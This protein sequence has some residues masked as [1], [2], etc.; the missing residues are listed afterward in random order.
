MTFI[1]DK[2]NRPELIYVSSVDDVWHFT[3][4]GMTLCAGVNHLGQWFSMPR[5]DYD[6]LKID[7]DYFGWKLL[8]TLNPILIH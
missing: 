7:T 8:Q 2:S 5:E 1:S 6:L 4:I 3:Y